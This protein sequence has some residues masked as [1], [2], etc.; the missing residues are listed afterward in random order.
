MESAELHLVATFK[1]LLCTN[2][3]CGRDQHLSSHASLLTPLNMAFLA[4][5]AAS[6]YVGDKL[7]ENFGPE[8][9]HTS[10]RI[11]TQQL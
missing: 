9:R 2:Y 7:E 3:Y 1:E 10:T 6:K 11:H 5:F 4:K 8:V